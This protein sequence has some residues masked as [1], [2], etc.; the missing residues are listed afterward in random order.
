[1][2]RH[3]IVGRSH[4]PFIDACLAPA[5]F[6]CTIHTTGL[7]GAITLLN[8]GRGG[9]EITPPYN[10]CMINDDHFI[11]KSAGAKHDLYLVAACS[12]H[13]YTSLPPVPPSLLHFLLP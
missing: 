10:S 12:F 8:W 9:G 5:H 6:H 7:N 11:L 2:R 1:M 4:W 13:A 3:F